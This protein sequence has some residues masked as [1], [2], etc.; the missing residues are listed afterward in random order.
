MASSDARPQGPVF[1]KE[2][3]AFVAI[4]LLGATLAAAV[5]PPKARRYW[6]L[7]QLEAQLVTRNAD[8]ARKIEVLEAATYSMQTDPLYR[9]AAMRKLLGV[10]KKSE[11]FLESGAPAVR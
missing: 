11:E 5:L 10:K 9:E 1:W 6:S 4:C 8:L 7:R 2:L 3:Y